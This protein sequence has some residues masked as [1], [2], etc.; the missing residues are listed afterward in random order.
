MASQS[1][2]PADLERYSGPKILMERSM[3]RIL[4]FFISV[5]LAIAALPSFGQELSAQSDRI[6]S[7]RST[8]ERLAGTWETTYVI[9]KDP[10]VIAASDQPSKHT[11]EWI[12][13]K[14]YLQE[15]GT[16]YR[17]RQ[18]LALYSYNFHGGNQ[19]DEP[20]KCSIMKSEPRP[21][22]EMLGKW[23]RETNTL[24][25]KAHPGVG[26]SITATYTF[27]GPDSYTFVYEIED[28]GK[29]IIHI[30]GSAKR[31]AASR[32]ASE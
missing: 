19:G 12:L 10:R 11:T 15:T 24:I 28:D 21:P 25:W 13:D 27:S 22:L 4:C 20:F 30:V 23:N 17:G 1:C 18:Y 32:S 3:N 29:L 26:E 9:H 14:H 5:S 6:T 16:D 2:Q 7:V 8:L 31:L